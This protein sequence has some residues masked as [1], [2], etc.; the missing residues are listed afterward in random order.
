MN[1][2]LRRF[3]VIKL[4]LNLKTNHKI[5]EKVSKMYGQQ[6]S[7][8]LICIRKACVRDSVFWTFHNIIMLFLFLFCFCDFFTY[9]EQKHTFLDPVWSHSVGCL[10]TS[11][12]LGNH[13]NLSRKPNAMWPFVYFLSSEMLQK[14]LQKPDPLQWNNREL[15][16][17]SG[18]FCD[19]S[20]LQEYSKC[21]KMATLLE[22]S[23]I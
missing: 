22:L 5:K 10:I 21:S 17:T 18:F 20:A 12:C 16:N 7:I 11:S 1:V 2:R 3:Q 6:I 15:V 13:S 9:F 19:F 23:Q 14:W 8:L 4:K